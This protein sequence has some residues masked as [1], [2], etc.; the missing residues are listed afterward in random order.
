[1]C[2][3]L[4]TETVSV[5]VSSCAT[6]SA[7]RNARRWEATDAVRDHFAGFGLLSR[8]SRRAEERAAMIQWLKE[9]LLLT[10]L[11]VP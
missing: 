4:E 8:L 7:T 1:L 9:M 10:I 2:P 3:A 11:L 6:S 5:A